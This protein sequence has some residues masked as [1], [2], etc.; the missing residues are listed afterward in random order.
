[1]TSKQIERRF[2]IFKTVVAV[3]LALGLALVVISFVSE[4]PAEAIV[5]FMTGPFQRASRI[6]N[7]IEVM[8]P[9]MFTGV[10]ICILYQANQFSMIGEGAFLI[11]ANLCTWFAVTHENWAGLPLMLTVMVIAI[12]AGVTVSIVPAVLKVKFRANEVVSSIM[13]NYVIL[14]ISD[15]LFYYHFRDVASGQQASFPIPAQIKLP[16]LIPG[17]RLHAGIIIGLVLAVLAYFFIYRTKWGYEIR[18]VG[19]NQNFAKYSGISVLSVALSTQLIGGGIA[20]L[21]GAVEILGRYDRF[22]WFGTQ[23][24]FGF[25]GV[26]VGVL[27]KNNPLLVPVAA[28]LLAYMRTGADVMNR[29]SDVPIEFVDVVQGLIILFVAAEMF[30]AKY[31]HKLIV[32]NAKKQLEAK[33][34]AK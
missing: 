3:L 23:P 29:V 24:G 5:A 13:M 31:K 19:A 9:L 27:A 21:G 25:D 4:S 28:F 20:G 6:S 14:K 16:K 30:L 26:L 18:M 17:L 10:A 33:E 8:T 15:Y 2:E 7:I 32:N 34:A 11:G 12:V 1:M 22:I